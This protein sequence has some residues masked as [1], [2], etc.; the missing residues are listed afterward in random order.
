MEQRWRPSAAPPAWWRPRS[1]A[2]HGRRPWCC[3][4]Q[5]LREGRGFHFSRE[6][7]SMDQ[8]LLIP[9]LGGWTSIYQLFWCSPGVQGFDTLPYRETIESTG[10]MASKNPWGS[11]NVIP[12]EHTQLN[13]NPIWDAKNSRVYHGMFI[14][15]FMIKKPTVHISTTN[16]S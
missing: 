14:Y 9:I 15:S 11:S 13:I 8:Y 2:T 16:P 1:S 10:W 3:S 6:N 7:M 4:F 12:Q 5:C